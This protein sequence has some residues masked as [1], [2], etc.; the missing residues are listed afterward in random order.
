MQHKFLSQK[1]LKANHYT[2][3]TL[4]Q[5]LYTLWAPAGLFPKRR[6]Q[7]LW[8][9]LS[10]ESLCLFALSPLSVCLL[11]IP[12]IGHKYPELWRA[13]GKFPSSLCSRNASVTRL[14]CSVCVKTSTYCVNAWEC[15][16]SNEIY[17]TNSRPDSWATQLAGP[18]SVRM[19]KNPSLPFGI[20]FLYQVTW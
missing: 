19:K 1:R 13:E 12:F 8:P 14:S 6:M 11:S 7:K 10:W 2:E 3:N 5:P 17:C 16:C 18:C 4:C 20:D 15:L 9:F